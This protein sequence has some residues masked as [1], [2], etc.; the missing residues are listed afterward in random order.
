MSDVHQYLITMA[1]YF[2]TQMEEMYGTEI[3]M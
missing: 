1:T 3:I 2:F